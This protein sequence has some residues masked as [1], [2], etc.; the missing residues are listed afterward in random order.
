MIP[1][2]LQSHT[3]IYL[4]KWQLNKHKKTDYVIQ[5][6]RDKFYWFDIVF[7][8]YFLYFCRKVQNY[9]CYLL[10]DVIFLLRVRILIKLYVQN[11]TKFVLLFSFGYSQTARAGTWHEDVQ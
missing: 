6:I 2:A 11:F 7:V 8:E 3:L 10:G 9:A 5:C 1:N 4:N